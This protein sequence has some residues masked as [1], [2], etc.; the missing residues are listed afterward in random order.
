MKINWKILEIISFS[1]LF[2]GWDVLCYSLILNQKIT[3]LNSYCLIVIGAIIFFLF[4]QSIFYRLLVRYFSKSLFVCYSIFTFFLSVI[5]VERLFKINRH[6]HYEVEGKSYTIS[7]VWQLDGVLGHKAIPSSKGSFAYRI[8]ER[9]FAIP[10]TIDK[11]GHR[12]TGSSSDNKPKIEIAVVGC[13]FT[14]GDYV[15]DLETY[16]SQLAFLTGLNVVNYGG[17]GYG[18]AQMKIK[19][20]EIIA[21]H[22]PKCI[23]IQ[24]SPWLAKRAT[25]I[26]RESHFGRR[27]YPYFNNKFSV[28]PPVFNTSVVPFNA[29]ESDGKSWI[30]KNKFLIS[31]GIA[32]HIKDEINFKLAQLKIFFGLLPTPQTNRIL[33]EEKM[34]QYFIREAKKKRYTFNIT[35]IKISGGFNTSLV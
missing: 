33:L 14:F 4:F 18:L 27:A 9:E 10:I 15:G 17:S 11:N 28:V 1:C 7:S 16:S 12:L 21:L 34:Y 23:V 2:I 31:K 32:V 26:D 30:E 24:Y 22:K 8:K 6:Y 19:F 20:D 35:Q 25:R 13:S 5:V 3:N 29:W